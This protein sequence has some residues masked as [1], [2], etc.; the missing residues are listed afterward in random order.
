MNIDEILKTNNISLIAKL[1]K[2]DWK[3]IYFGAEPY[4]NAMLEIN[5]IKEN[6]F[7]DSAKSIVL[8]FLSNARTWKGENAKKIKAHLKNISK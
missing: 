8:Y 6:Y 3:N 4:L 5:N 7:E 2:D 1:I